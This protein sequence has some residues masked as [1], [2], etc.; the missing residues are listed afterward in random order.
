MVFMVGNKTDLDKRQV[1]AETAEKFAQDKGYPFMETS[2]KTGTSTHSWFFS[3][4]PPFFVCCHR[5]Y[6]SRLRPNDVYRGERRGVVLEAGTGDGISL[7]QDGGQAC[8]IYA[9]PGR[10][11]RAAEE[12]EG[13]HPLLTKKAVSSAPCTPPEGALSYHHTHSTLLSPPHVV[14]TLLFPFAS[15]VIQGIMS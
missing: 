9:Q 11:R 7:H 15:M 5:A 12:E 8:H 13:L 14:F 6:R 10:R 1:S 3:A 2:A 4:P